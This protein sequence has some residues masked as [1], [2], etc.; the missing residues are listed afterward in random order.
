MVVQVFLNGLFL[1]RGLVHRHEFC[2]AR[3]NGA[4]RFASV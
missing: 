4:G 1:H 2:G 3:A